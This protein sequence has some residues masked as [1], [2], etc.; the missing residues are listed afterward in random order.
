[1]TTTCHFSRRPTHLR[2]YVSLL[3]LQPKG[4][5]FQPKGIV[6]THALVSGPSIVVYLLAPAGDLPGVA[7]KR[8]W[9]HLVLRGLPGSTDGGRETLHH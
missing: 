2:Q 8:E 1:M 3:L 4:I 9:R 7:L 5:V 6:V